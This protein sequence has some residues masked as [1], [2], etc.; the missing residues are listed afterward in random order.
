MSGIGQRYIEGLDNGK[1]I[2]NW[3]ADIFRQQKNS[4]DFIDEDNI[5]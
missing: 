3:Y 2:M 5:I 4:I 1:V